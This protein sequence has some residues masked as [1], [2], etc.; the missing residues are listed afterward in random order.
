MG[1]I[2]VQA[3]YI[4]KNGVKW[5]PLVG[6][7]SWAGGVIFIDRSN[8]K[9]AARS[10][11]SAT[12]KVRR[13]KSVVIFPEGTRTRDGRVAPFKKGGFRL[14]MD[15]GV[16]IVPIAT[17]GGWEIL[18]K[19]AHR[20]N[21][22]NIKVIFGDTVYPDSYPTKEALMEEVE[23]QIRDMAATVRPMM[24]GTTLS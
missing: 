9:K 20:S 23:R 4:A 8:S 18:P 24:P 13:G 11:A 19:G 1:A 5:M 7:A 12:E 17:V 14:A 21:P 15:A 2:P 3:V 6:W 22:G 10:M 16:P